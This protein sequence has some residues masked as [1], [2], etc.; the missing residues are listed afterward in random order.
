VSSCQLAVVPTG[1]DLWADLWKAL[2]GSFAGG[3]FLKHRNA[4]LKII[5]LRG[6]F[7]DIKSENL[8]I[9]VS[10][11]VVQKQITERPGCAV[12]LDNDTLLTPSI[13]QI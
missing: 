13:G 12:C 7:A 10:W 2:L 3:E 6:D 8:R 11:Y 9:T 1:V 4:L 5:G